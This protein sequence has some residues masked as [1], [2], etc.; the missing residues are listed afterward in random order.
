MVLGPGQLPTQGRVSAQAP[1]VR[2]CVRSVD[3]EGRP[4]AVWRLRRSRY[5][6][7]QPHSPRERDRRGVVAQLVVAR[8]VLER[9]IDDQ[10]L[11]AGQTLA[12]LSRGF[13]HDLERQ[14]ERL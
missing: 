12:C 5:Q 6:R 7:L 13:W 2:S 11:H 8:L 4:S 14:R 3:T 10:L 9:A 1:C